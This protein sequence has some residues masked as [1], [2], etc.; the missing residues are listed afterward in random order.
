MKEQDNVT[1]RIIETENGKYVCTDRMRKDENEKAIQ[2]ELMRDSE[3]Q[4]K[5]G[6]ITE[7]H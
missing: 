2:L 5:T 6:R 1:V 4:R 3:K 7:R